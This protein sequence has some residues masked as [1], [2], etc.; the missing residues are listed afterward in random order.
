LPFLILSQDPAKAPPR[1]PKAMVI[2]W[3]QM[4]EDLKKLSTRSRRIIAVGSTHYI[5]IDRPDL[6]NREVLL[7]IQQVRGTAPQPTNYGITGT[8]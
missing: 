7:F 4:Q 8:E 6:V 1:E 5:Q 3:Q 2:A